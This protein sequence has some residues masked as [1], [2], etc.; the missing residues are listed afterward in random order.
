MKLI[1]GQLDYLLYCILF[2][3][4][5]SRPTLLVGSFLLLQYKLIY[6]SA[7]HFII[8]TCLLN[9]MVLSINADFFVVVGLDISLI[10]LTRFSY[11]TWSI[12]HV[13]RSLSFLVSHIASK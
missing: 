3:V 2:P 10:S 8:F 1:L 9:L 4:E 7:F 12:I 13:C 6:F 5:I 11:K